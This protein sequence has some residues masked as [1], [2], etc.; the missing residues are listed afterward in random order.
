MFSSN[1]LLLPLGNCSNNEIAINIAVWFFFRERIIGDFELVLKLKSWTLYYDVKSIL[2]NRTLR[3][4][5]CS[6]FH[7]VD[8]AQNYWVLCCVFWPV[9][10]G[11]RIACACVHMVENNE[12]CL[13]TIIILTFSSPGVDEF[14]WINDNAIKKTHKGGPNC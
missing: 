7:K 5:V 2:R 4:Y 9:N 6:A 13:K 11:L 14:Q 8:K 12:K 1:S 10:A 3:A